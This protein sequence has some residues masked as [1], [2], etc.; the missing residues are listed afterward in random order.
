MGKILGPLATAVAIAGAVGAVVAVVALPWAWYGAIDV[1]LHRFPL[2]GLHAFAAAALNV[3]VGWIL[4]ARGLRLL[5]WVGV[6]LC[7]ATV[8][9]AALVMTFYCDATALFGPVVPM[10]V[11]VLGPGGPVAVLAAVSSVTAIGVAWLAE[12]N[13][14]APV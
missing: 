2:W 7:L 5:W 14:R 11:P 4:V 13:A 10:V 6:A 1:K 3:T 9:S 8:G 12:R